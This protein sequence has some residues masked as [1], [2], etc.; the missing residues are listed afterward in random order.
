MKSKA[1]MPRKKLVFLDRDGTINKESGL[2]EKPEQLELIPGAAEGIKLLNDFGFIVVIVTNQPQVARGICT[3]EEVKRINNRLLEL[4]HFHNAKIDAV[5]YCPHH[6]DKG[7][8]GERKEYKIDCD[9]RKPKI[10]M[11]KQASEQFGIPLKD[12]Y[13]VGDH[14]RDIK[15]AENAGCKSIGV[16]T[17]SGCKDG[18]YPSV[19]Y[20]LSVDLLE[21]SKFIVA[22]ETLDSS[23]I[24]KIPAV[25]IAGG[26]GKRLAPLTELIP[27]PLLPAEGGK[28]VL[29]HQIVWLKREGIKEI[30]LCTGYLSEKIESYFGNGSKFGVK[31][32]YSVEPEELGTGGALKN[33][34]RLIAGRRFVALYGDLLIDVDLRRMIAY[35][36]AKG[37]LGTLAL[38]PTNHPFDSDMLKCNPSGKIIAFLGKPKPGQE[39]ENLGNAG[40]YCLESAILKYFPANRSMLDKEVLPKVIAGGGNLYGFV[41]FEKI[42]DMGTHDRY[43][44]HRG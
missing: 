33:A 44:K 6:P 32:S 19:P 35:H 36:I 30:I 28:P 31:I 26:L 7:Y 3:E 42:A 9:C 8:A 39:F 34:E 10:G 5:Y 25:I 37:S 24:S 21:A 43:K 22:Y 4:L 27:K 15:A 23:A 2:I 20:I 12:C 41:T 16:M 1:P 14:S 40:L 38:H 11:L 29:E 13:F 17:G 18:K